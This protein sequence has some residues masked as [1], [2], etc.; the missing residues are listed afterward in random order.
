VYS[1]KKLWA[2]KKAAAPAKD[3]RALRNNC[4]NEPL[5]SILIP[6]HNSEDS[7]G[8]TL[9]SVLGQTWPN[10]EIIVVDDGSTD[11]TAEVVRRFEADG[12]RLV[13]QRSQGASAARNKAFS[14]SHG[15]YIQWL[16]AD[17][18]LSPEKI[19]TQVNWLSTHGGKRTLVSCAW[20]KFLHRYYRAK[21]VPTALWCD[22][23]PVEWLLRKMGQNIY[24]QTGSWLVSRELTEAV[25][26]WDTRLTVDDDG[27]YF[28]RA[29]M[30]SD[31]VQFVPEGKVYYRGPGFRSL[32][33]IGESVT[34]RES[35]WLSMQLH[36]R[37]IR[38]LED[39]ERVRAACLRYLRESLIHFYPEHEEIVEQ[40]RELAK[41]LGQDLGSPKLSWK[42]RWID[43]LF[44]FEAAKNTQLRGLDV[45]WW[46]KKN[47]DKAVFLV[48][49]A[50]SAQARGPIGRTRRAQ[51]GTAFS[52]LH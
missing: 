1:Q 34:R 29:I 23:S 24:M 22:L 12:V 14:V 31:G 48:E 44:G 11:R 3:A 27:E 13:L 10:T 51:R 17:D 9:R 43:A 6:A 33:H 16:D 50:K 7:I 26:P 38:C 45:K 37:Y 46:V 42:Y 28:C 32:S 47:L 41:E 19:A 39:S 4:N 52:N 25:G 8:D 49:G 30:A 5:V 15:E 21:F 2:R 35:L 20:G 18:L 40:A 36:V